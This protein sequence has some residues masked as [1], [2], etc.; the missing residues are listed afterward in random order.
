MI[1]CATEINIIEKILTASDS[2]QQQQQQKQGKY[3]T[4]LQPHDATENV[5]IAVNFF[6]HFS[7]RH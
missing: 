2:K 1:Q 5:L 4:Q 7:N 3:C 6:F